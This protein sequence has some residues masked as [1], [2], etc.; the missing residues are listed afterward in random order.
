MK[1]GCAIIE[2]E[3]APIRYLITV[4]RWEGD[5][6]TETEGQDVITA[7]SRLISETERQAHIRKHNF[8]TPIT[9]TRKT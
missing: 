8:K 1:Y 9:G 5:D 4:T 7:Y 3:K 6:V 2:G